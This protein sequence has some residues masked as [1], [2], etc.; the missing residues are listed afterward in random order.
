MAPKKRHQLPVSQKE[1]ND[2]VSESGAGA[3]SIAGQFAS[4]RGVKGEQRTREVPTEQERLEFGLLDTYRIKYCRLCDRSSLSNSEI[5]DD[6]A[7]GALI[8]WGGGTRASPA[9]VFCRWLG[10]IRN[11]YCEF[12]VC[13]ST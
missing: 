13:F 10:L 11:L 12:D 5:G 3:K 9:G 8:Q 4:D 1:I 7:W 6:S 2:V